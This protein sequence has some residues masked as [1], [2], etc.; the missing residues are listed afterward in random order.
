MFVVN[1]DKTIECTRGDAGSFSVS[2]SMGE[3]SYLFQPNDVLRLTVCAKKDYS[4]IMLQKDTNVISA[5]TSVEISLDSD[6]TKFGGVINKPTEFW[7]T[8]E[9]NPDGYNCQTLVGHTKDGASVFM[10]YPE[11]VG[12]EG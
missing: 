11:A 4:N 5:T 10:L 8:I 6:E 2:A 1:E 12:Q 9:L 3:A 7:Y